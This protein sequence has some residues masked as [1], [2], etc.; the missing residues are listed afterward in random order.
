MFFPIIL[1]SGSRWSKM[2]KKNR[3][4]GA[5]NPQNYMGFLTFGKI[6]YKLGVIQV[7]N[8]TTEIQ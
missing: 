7:K 8:E 2:D 1:Q 4:K 5:I 3:T 6:I